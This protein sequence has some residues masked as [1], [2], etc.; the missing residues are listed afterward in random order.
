MSAPS[1]PSRHVQGGVDLTDVQKAAAE[2]DALEEEKKGLQTEKKG[3]QTEK[4]K[5]QAKET[6]LQALLVAV[7]K[8]QRQKAALPTDIESR[9]ADV[10]VCGDDLASVFEQLTEK[11]KTVQRTH[12][13]LATAHAHLLQQQTFAM[14]QQQQGTKV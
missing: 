6:E 11:L 5:L 4:K 12:E 3:L 7:G 1:T 9:V 13:Q 14:Q 2:V 10:G 8:A